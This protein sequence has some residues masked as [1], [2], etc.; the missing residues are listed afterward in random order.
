MANFAYLRVSKDTQDV[1]NQKFG[2]LDY[3]NKNQLAPVTL[4]EDT[5]SRSKSW[6]KR[7]I[8]IILD[9]SGEGDTLIASEISRLGGSP[10]Q[11]LEILVERRAAHAC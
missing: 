7:G 1:E 8:G 5:E 11:V 4:V 3:C 6:R 9:Q 10:L 2:I